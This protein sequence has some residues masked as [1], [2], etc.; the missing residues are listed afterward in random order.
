MIDRAPGPRRRRRSAGH[1]ARATPW[2]PHGRRHRAGP[3]ARTRGADGQRHL[4]GARWLHAAGPLGS[5]GTHPRP[6]GRGRRRVLPRRGQGPAPRGQHPQAH[7]QPDGRGPRRALPRHR[8]SPVARADH[9]AARSRAR[10]GGPARDARPPPGPRVRAPPRCRAAVGHHRTRPGRPARRGAAPPGRAPRAPRAAHPRGRGD[11]RDLARGRRHADPGGAAAR[12]AQRHA[13]ARRTRGLPA[14]AHGARAADALPADGTCPAGA[15]P[16]RSHRRSRP[17]P[18]RP[19]RLPPAA[20]RPRPPTRP[21]PS[22][23]A[24]H[25]C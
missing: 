4:P 17:R 16:A 2:P 7:R 9:P 15:H 19:R 3:A 20:G 13:G 21:P 23:G 11:A 14:R 22:E 10:V 12:S 6:R 8:R 24:R 5:R 1:H 25:R 18:P